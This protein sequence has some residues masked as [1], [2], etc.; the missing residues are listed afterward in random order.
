MTDLASLPWRTGRS[1]GRTVYARTGGDDWKADTAIGM[2]DT[3][4]LA[5][6]ACRAHNDA[7]ALREAARRRVDG[8]HPDEGKTRRPA[9]REHLAWLMWCYDQGYT[10]PADRADLTNWM[11]NDPAT[12]HSHDVERQRALLGMADEVLALLAEAEREG[13]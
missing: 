8:E 13:P 1:L 4:E 2:M 7:L 10:N 9:P 11:G 3:R 12:L 5:E 6:A